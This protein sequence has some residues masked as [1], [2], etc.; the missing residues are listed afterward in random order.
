LPF[1]QV[2]ECVSLCYRASPT[3]L[4][5]VMPIIFAFDSRKTW[6]SGAVF[7]GVHTS[8]LAEAFVRKVKGSLGK[9][10]AQWVQLVPSQA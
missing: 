5:A 3:N 2:V 8:L 6:P 9:L 10:R 7:R 1:T 4:S